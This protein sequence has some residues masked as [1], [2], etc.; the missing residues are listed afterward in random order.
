[1]GHTGARS[2]RVL[3]SDYKEQ[4]TSLKAGNLTG[5]L[6]LIAGDVDD[7]VNPCMTMQLVDAFINAD[8]HLTC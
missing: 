2:T 7:N 4:I 5:K 8:G 3:K 6:L 1:M